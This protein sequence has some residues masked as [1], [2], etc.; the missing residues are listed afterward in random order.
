MKSNITVERYTMKSNI[1]VERCTM[2]S[3]IEAVPP[4]SPTLPFPAE[5]KI[6]FHADFGQSPNAFVNVTDGAPVI[7]ERTLLNLGNGYNLSAGVFTAP[8]PGMYLF[9]LQFMAGAHNE[10][11]E[12]AAYV[13]GQQVM[14]V[15][16]AVGYYRQNS[17]QGSCTA[18][19]QLEQGQ[20]VSVKVYDGAPTIWGSRLTSFTGALLRSD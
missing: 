11:T 14:C 18:V 13:D 12:L 15:A 16:F 5:P 3:N 10:T 4:S 2:K 17:D 9:S 7:F 6:G 19:V 8:V 1:A 20:V